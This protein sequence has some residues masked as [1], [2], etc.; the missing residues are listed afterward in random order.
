MAAMVPEGCPLTPREFE[1]MQSLCETGSYQETAAALGISRSTVTT[2]VNN[3]HRKLG[4]VSGVAAMAVMGQRGWV[5]WVEAEPE[6]QAV[7]L[8]IER[9]FLAAYLQHFGDRWPAVEPSERAREAM[10]LALAGNALHDDHST[11]TTAGR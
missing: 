4:V 6:L 7:P 10:D 11:T 5:G 9:P 1:V 2:H 3:A 8:A